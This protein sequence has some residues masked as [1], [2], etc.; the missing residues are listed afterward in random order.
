MIQNEITLSQHFAA[1]VFK[2][3]TGVSYNSFSGSAMRDK[4][5]LALKKDIT[6]KPNQIKGQELLF[7]EMYQLVFSFSSF[8]ILG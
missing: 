6:N 5:L 1:V 4:F 8:Y 7:F 3:F 2:N